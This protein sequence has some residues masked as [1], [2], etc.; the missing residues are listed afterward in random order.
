LRDVFDERDYWARGA[1]A[2][3]V[4]WR[5]DEA[6]DPIKAQGRLERRCESARRTSETGCAERGVRVAAA[7]DV[8]GSSGCAALSRFTWSPRAASPL[9]TR[10][11]SLA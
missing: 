9:P 3:F 5:V 7:P 6:G 11:G 8:R 1:G 2:E 10:P 4:E